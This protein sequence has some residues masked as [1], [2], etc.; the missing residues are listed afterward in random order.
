[1][2]NSECESGIWNL[3]FHQ[4]TSP[5][6]SK[7]GSS[8]TAEGR[9]A[10]VVEDDAINVAHVARRG[11]GNRTQPSRRRR[12]HWHRENAVVLDDSTHLAIRSH[13][14]RYGLQQCRGLRPLSPRQR[15][16]MEPVLTAVP[17]TR[18]SSPQ[19]E[20]RPVGR[21]FLNKETG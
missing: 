19:A 13:N 8:N 3:E 18:L 21:V 16:A 11:S 5:H 14:S 17:P 12:R 7:G 1:M 20:T 2:V 6:V 15:L 4:C 9:I 10:R